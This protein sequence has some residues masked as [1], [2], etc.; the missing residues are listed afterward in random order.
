MNL[1][2]RNLT[3]YLRVKCLLFA[4]LFINF[5]QPLYA[6]VQQSQIS[7]F[8]ITW[9]FDKDYT[10]GQF[11]NGDY[12]VVG[13]VTI[14]KIQPASVELNG[15]TINGSMINRGSDVLEYDPDQRL[16]KITVKKPR[17]IT[18]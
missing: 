4:M 17:A 2:L 14:I 12:W 10:V 6:A 1:N 7:Q 16:K 5:A 18:P 3:L 8:G 11:T 13:P 15:R 9:T